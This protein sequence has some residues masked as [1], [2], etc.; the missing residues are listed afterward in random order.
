MSVCK[1]III[2]VTVLQTCGICLESREWLTSVMIMGS[3]YDLSITI[4]LPQT[5]DHW[6]MKKIST[7]TKTSLKWYSKRMIDWHKRVPA[8]VT[9]SSV[10]AQDIGLLSTAAP[11]LEEIFMEVLAIRE[12]QRSSRVPHLC[13]QRAQRLCAEWKSIS[14]HSKVI[15]T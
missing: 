5:I 15:F 2:K 3:Q 8:E 4:V 1:R 10:A 7:M 11:S 12:L 6:F 14:H 9:A 13:W